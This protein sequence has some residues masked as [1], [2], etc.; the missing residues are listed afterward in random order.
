M[1]TPLSR[2]NISCPVGEKF[3]G[4][5]WQMVS[6]PRLA[7]WIHQGNHMLAPGGGTLKCAVLWCWKISSSSAFWDCV[8]A[9]P[10]L[11]TNPLEVTQPCS[12][13]PCSENEVCSINR[14]K[15][16]HPDF[17]QPYTCKPGKYKHIFYTILSYNAQR[18][19]DML[20][21]NL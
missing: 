15:C 2:T 18:N 3:E 16:K 4:G 19:V 21:H 5:T 12:S 9:E 14:R 20:V 11:M 13:N 1:I 8:F 10:G 7:D 6:P 17:C